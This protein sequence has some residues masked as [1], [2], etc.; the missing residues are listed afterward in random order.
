MFTFSDGW[1][2]DSHPYR[3]LEFGKWELILPPKEDGSPAISHLS[4]LKVSDKNSELPD[5]KL[6]DYEL[7]LMYVFELKHIISKLIFNNSTFHT[8]K[9]SIDCVFYEE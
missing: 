5:Q 7:I 2:R 4:E 1:N 3:K 8:I 9:F 6:N